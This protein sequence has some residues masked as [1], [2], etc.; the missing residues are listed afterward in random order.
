MQIELIQQKDKSSSPYRRMLDAGFSGL[1]HTA[2]LCEDIDGGVERTQAA[3]F[4]L[5]CDIRM[6]DGARYAYMQ[7]DDLGDDIYVELLEYT[8][9]M[10]TLFREGVAAAEA[11]TGDMEITEIDMRHAFDP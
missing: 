8:D 9:T 11:W 1:H 7:S 6:P 5:A 2:Y 4:E 3:G 10:K